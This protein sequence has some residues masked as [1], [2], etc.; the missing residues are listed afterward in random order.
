M[1]VAAFRTG[2]KAEPIFRW[3]TAVWPSGW[4]GAVNVPVA[5]TAASWMTNATSTP[6]SCRCLSNTLR[7]LT[8]GGTLRSPSP[9]PLTCRERSS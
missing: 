4:P 6:T 1:V 7:E 2:K 9:I 5:M 3:R 8:M